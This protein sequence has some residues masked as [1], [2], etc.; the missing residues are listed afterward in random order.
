MCV[1]VCVCSAASFAKEA[2]DVYA[3][4]PDAETNEE[5]AQVCVCVCV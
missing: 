2:A 3:Y 1:C 5:Y 4:M